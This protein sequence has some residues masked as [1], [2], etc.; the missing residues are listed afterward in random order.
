[1]SN[2]DLKETPAP[3]T[4]DSATFP[5]HGHCLIEASAGTGKTY[6]ISNLYLRL[7]TGHGDEASKAVRPLMPDDI[8]AI[9]FTKAA[10]QELK[11]RI[12]QRIHLAQ[13]AFS[14]MLV[15]D[16]AFI[17]QL[18]D[19][20]PDHKAMAERLLAAE[21]QMDE[22]AIFTIHGFC[23][24]MLGQ[25][26]FESGTLFNLSLIED[27]QHLLHQAVADF[28]RQRFY[29][30]SKEKNEHLYQ[31]WQSPAQLL[32][33]L[34][35]LLNHDELALIS[36]DTLN[37]EERYQRLKDI[38]MQLKTDW[39]KHADSIQKLI[40]CSDIKKQSYSKKNLPKWINDIKAWAC[41]SCITPPEAL[42]KFTSG[43]MQEKTKAG[44]QPPEHFLFDSTEL[45]LGMPQEFKDI[46]LREALEGVKTRLAWLKNQQQIMTFQDLITG[47]DTALTQSKDQALSR[48]IREEFPVA[49]ID[50]FQD[51]DIIQYRIFSTLYPEKNHRD[52]ALLMV[53]DPK[54]AIYAFRG[55]DIFTYINVRRITALR[56][57]LSKNWRSTPAMIDVC[58]TLFSTSAEPFLYDEDIPFVPAAVAEKK[59]RKVF[60][61][62]N[63]TVPALSIWYQAGDNGDPVNKGRYHD[64]MT[65]ATVREIKHLLA[66]AQMTPSKACFS[67]S[68]NEQGDCLKANDIAVLVRTGV[69]AKSVQKALADNGISSVYMSERAS[70]FDT[71]EAHDIYRILSACLSPENE[72][73]LRSALATPLFNLTAVELEKLRLD[74]TLWENTVNVFASYHQLWLKRGVLS[75]LRELSFQQKIAVKLLSDPMGERRLTDLTH[76]GELLSSA[77]QTLD[78]QQALINWLWLHIQNSRE[79]TAFKLHLESDADVV[80]IITIHKSKGLEYPIVFMPFV[81]DWR[82][83]DNK[84]GV[85]FHRTSDNRPILDLTG[86]DNAKNLAEKERLAEDIR[87]FYVG[88][89]RAIHRCYIG[90]API[91]KGNRKTMQLHKTAVGHL[92]AGT[93]EL[94]PA[95]L[96]AHIN[97]QWGKNKQLM[98]TV[99]PFAEKYT[100]YAPD[101]ADTEEL[102]AREFNGSIENNWYVTS[103]STLS[104]NSHQT[105]VY[106]RA[107]LEDG[108]IDE[109]APSLQGPEKNIFTFPRGARAGVF[110]HSLFEK[111]NF[112]EAS[113][114]SPAGIIEKAL[115]HDGFESAWQETLA[116]LVHN[117][118]KAPLSPESFC[119]G[120][121]GND[122]RYVEMEFHLP[123]TTL[124]AGSLNRLI[125][126]HDPLSQYAGNLQFNA[127]KGM[128]KGFIDLTFKYKNKYYVADYKSNYLGDNT[129]DYHPDNIK[130]AMC[131]HRYDLQYQLYTLALHRFLRQRVPGYTYESSFG[132]VFYLFIRGMQA[133]GQQGTGIFFTRPAMALV[134]GLDH[135][136]SGTLLTEESAAGEN[137]G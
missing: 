51:T 136:F 134:D 114:C 89:T 86:S 53:G 133:D 39:L 101:S 111:I 85:F 31:Y 104:K 30:A 73:A 121:I 131:E 68:E 115:L 54:Q 13:Q 64:S 41:D 128:L 80:R 35:P 123:L 57:T 11:Q 132:G 3:A 61:L 125:K 91:C 120:D 84:D 52:Y 122:H 21:R 109:Q 137:A 103:Y 45:F 127:L 38:S 129:D 72:S 69:Q 29:S 48:K 15:S 20:L 58:N 116:Q 23:Q 76:I 119:L 112:V 12:R 95:E 37:F 118:L 107:G 70:V 90:M 1:M 87:L 22:A 4:L 97:K 8:L 63:K 65:Q 124:D 24:R 44:G 7:I 59:E 74:E 14:G 92:L 49:I 19:D 81:C 28:W 43:A 50:E 100:A 10:T 108:L 88:V 117:V 9:T 135:L 67:V 102:S 106:E 36:H 71:P 82:E 55:A 46:F 18:L 5:L 27:E 40:D 113:E 105:P 16:D 26:A 99:S 60:Y 110:L 75:M 96:H 78:S 83:A 47:F 56:F 33:S 34:R 42:K 66:M 93:G 25:H 94:T 2:N 130:R 17:Q 32:T 62:N 77:E 79:D 98:E 126:K 6:T